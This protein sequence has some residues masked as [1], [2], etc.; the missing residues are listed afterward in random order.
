M[1]SVMHVPNDIG[2]L[3]RERRS[4][5]GFTLI[6]LLVVI[7]I[8]GVL[9]GMLLPALSR[10][11]E[12]AHGISCMSNT[13]QLAVAWIL[14][15][16]D[17]QG[18]LAY[19]LGGD[20]KSR[21]VALRTNVNWVNNVMTW[22]TADE[23]T[24][25]LTITEASLAPYASRAVKI[26]R[27][28]SDRVLSGAQRDAGWQAR[29]RSYS[30]NAMIGDAGDLSL[31]GVNKNNPSYIQFF[32]ITAIPEPVKIFVFLDEHPD[33]INDGYFVNKAYSHEWYDLP[34]SYHNGAA[35]LSFADGH[36]ETHRWRYA[37]TR[38]P[39]RANTDGPPLLPLPFENER[40]DFDWLMQRMSVHTP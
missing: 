2:R 38:Q 23:N 20:A 35:G 37:L 6:E 30:M 16:D 31:T 36:A 32:K 33:S 21:T 7:G 24:N 10:A 4:E 12:K 19:N 18:R 26:Y 22:D 1:L 9:A 25:L 40:G 13:K 5:R 3:A 29:I 8:V 39:A 17:H 27:C 28:P 34:A 11:R 14:Y 15:A